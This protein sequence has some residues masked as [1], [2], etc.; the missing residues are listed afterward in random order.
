[1][2]DGRV[3]F[4]LLTDA[5]IWWYLYYLEPSRCRKMCEIG[6]WLRTDGNFHRN[7]R[8]CPTWNLSTKGWFGT[9]VAWQ[10]GTFFASKNTAI[11]KRLEPCCRFTVFPFLS[12]RASWTHDQWAVG[13][14]YEKLKHRLLT[15]TEDM[16][17]PTKRKIENV[18]LLSFYHNFKDSRSKLLSIFFE[19]PNPDGAKTIRGLA[20][21]PKSG[22][23]RCARNRCCRGWMAKW[24]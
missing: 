13:M 2:V 14:S 16:A 11:K 5:G 15:F 3:W 24:I 20:W 19:A 21:W 1:M 4:L 6:Q 12:A 9:M 23:F 22:F 17:T 10:F 7:F 8:R 18:S